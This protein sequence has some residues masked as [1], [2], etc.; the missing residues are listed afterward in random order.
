MK[1]FTLIAVA[2]TGIFAGLGVYAQGI[3]LERKAETQ[4]P[5]TDSTPAKVEPKSPFENEGTAVTLPPP[6]IPP[7]SSVGS[8]PVN[9]ESVL[10]PSSIVKNKGS[11]G[12]DRSAGAA[13]PVRPSTDLTAP[14]TTQFPPESS[15]QAQ[16]DPVVNAPSVVREPLVL[17]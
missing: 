7:L 15:N 13:A 9:K 17:F 16:T 11:S 6:P 3:S 14:P 8:S 2:L 4:N 12:Q 1:R 5:F 10:P